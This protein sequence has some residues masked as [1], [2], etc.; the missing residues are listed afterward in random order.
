MKQSTKVNLIIFFI[1]AVIAFAFST[2]FASVSHIDVSNSTKLTAIEDDGFQPHEIE[3][4]HVVVPVVEN[5]TNNTNSWTNWTNWTSDI[6][7][8]VDE[9]INF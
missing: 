4:V 2:A 5:K 7:E 3:N 1:I 8:V 9:N 6:I